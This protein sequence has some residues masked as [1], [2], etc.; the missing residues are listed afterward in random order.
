MAIGVEFAHSAGQ[1]STNIQ[2]ESSCAEPIFTFASES[3]AL[4]AG[5]QQSSC[6]FG[7]IICYRLGTD[8]FKRKLRC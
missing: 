7:L 3:M 6:L 8:T 2:H 5:I 1:Q 4:I